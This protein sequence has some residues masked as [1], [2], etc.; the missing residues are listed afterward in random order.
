MLRILKVCKLALEATLAGH[1]P[2][3]LSLRL[4][5]SPPPQAGDVVLLCPT[6]PAKGTWPVRGTARVLRVEPITLGGTAPPP[7]LTS[8]LGPEL[9]SFCQHLW[10]KWLSQQNPPAKAH[11]TWLTDITSIT[12]TADIAAFASDLPHPRT[13][14]QLPAISAPPHVLRQLRALIGALPVAGAA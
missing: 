1:K 5:R 2:W 4:A 13:C 12:P 11:L 3:E 14:N 8:T 7:Y 6:G 9:R 10:S